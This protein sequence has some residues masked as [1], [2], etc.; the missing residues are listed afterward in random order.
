MTKSI[1]DFAADGRTMLR[2]TLATV[3]DT[4]SCSTRVRLV[5]EGETVMTRTHGGHVRTYR[6][7]PPPDATVAPR[8]YCKLIDKTH[9]FGLSGVRDPVTFDVTTN[10]VFTVPDFQVTKGTIRTPSK[11][12][13]DTSITDSPGPNHWV[14]SRVTPQSNHLL[15]WASAFSSRSDGLRSYSAM[16]NPAYVAEYVPVPTVLYRQNEYD[17]TVEAGE[18]YPG[19]SYYGQSPWARFDK[20]YDS[21][22]VLYLDG[23]RTTIAGQIV[24]AAV[25]HSPAKHIRVVFANG[26]HTGITPQNW[27]TFSQVCY[28]MDGAALDNSYPHV[29][30]TYPAAIDYVRHMHFPPVFN[31]SGTEIVM[32]VEYMPAGGPS[33]KYAV[34]TG[35]AQTGVLSELDTNLRSSS[36]LT[37]PTMT[38]TTA[39]EVCTIDGGSDLVTRITVGEQT[40]HRIMSLGYVAD[41]VNYVA[42]SSTT[43]ADRTDASVTTHIWDGG[44][45]EGLFNRETTGTTLT[46][47]KLAI[48]PAGTQLLTWSYSEEYAASYNDVWVSA[49]SLLSTTT[50]TADYIPYAVCSDFARGLHVVVTEKGSYTSTGF[51]QSWTPTSYTIAAGVSTYNVDVNAT[52]YAS[53]GAV[54]CS[55]IDKTGAQHS[56]NSVAEQTTAWSRVGDLFPCW[57]DHVLAESP[58]AHTPSVSNLTLFSPSCIDG[59]SIAFNKATTQ[60]VF[61]MLMADGL[62][63]L[64][65]SLTAVTTYNLLLKNTNGSWSTEP[66]TLPAYVGPLG[67]MMEPVFIEPRA[68]I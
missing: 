11:W 2:K 46:T 28:S 64:V 6:I 48:Y 10:D 59:F 29:T 5:G 27:F 54:V 36:T 31:S 66:I 32:G 51:G 58:V 40:V 45:Y 42:M 38:T 55:I 63:Y 37:R 25:C 56:V 24:C 49:P 26:S 4:D 43:D 22:S 17:Y 60:G 62:D 65:P 30:Y 20:P 33:F 41:Q 35:D 7:L 21:G 18:C 15:Q 1:R 67:W 61:S 53:T 19:Q 23:K 52:L 50:S 44:T 8:F 47:G 16:S 68:I 13:A 9:T 12:I 57:G 39:G 3:T 14:D 34:F